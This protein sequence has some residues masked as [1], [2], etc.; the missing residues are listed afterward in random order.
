MGLHHLLINLVRKEQ[1]HIFHRLHLAPPPPSGD[2]RKVNETV[3]NGDRGP[4]QPYFDAQGGGRFYGTGGAFVDPIYGNIQYGT[5]VVPPTLAGDAAQYNELF[6]PYL[7][8]NAPSQTLAD[9]DKIGLGLDFIRNLNVSND[10]Y[11]QLLT[12]W[13]NQV[14]TPLYQRRIANAQTDVE[15][16]GVDLRP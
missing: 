7:Y 15:V 4:S 10:E 3:V 6:P 1:I 12:S 2:D 11:Q 14:F 16:S 13:W 5:G 8:G 9:L